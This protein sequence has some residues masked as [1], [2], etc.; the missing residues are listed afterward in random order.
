MNYV[1]VP[2]EKL[3]VNKITFVKAKENQ[4]KGTNIPKEKIK[5]HYM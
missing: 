4:Y 1:S 2:L 3:D 5:Y